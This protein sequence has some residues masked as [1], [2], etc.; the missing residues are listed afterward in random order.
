MLPKV[1]DRLAA[2]LPINS[3]VAMVEVDDPYEKGAR[4]A[5][6]RSVRDDPLARLHCRGH[7][8]QAQYVA[9]RAWQ[10]DYEA[11]EVG[12][13]GAIDPAKEAVDGRRFV[14]PETA[15][16]S[17]ALV[18]L[19]RDDRALGQEGAILIRRVLVHGMLFEQIA[20]ERGDIGQ[21]MVKYLGKRFR[22]TL[23]TLAQVRGLVSQ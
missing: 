3:V 6:L 11:A 14:E 21:A 7:I 8:D 20:A 12:N 1:H 9:G 17:A 15:K 2:D 22:E 10:A 19:A 23:E 18:R 13:V 16:R 5:V 4:I